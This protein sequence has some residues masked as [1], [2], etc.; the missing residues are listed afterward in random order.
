MDFFGKKLDK[1]EILKHFAKP[2]C[3]VIV[4][5]VTDSTNTRARDML[6]HGA[7]A[8]FLLAAEEQTAGRGRHGNSFFSPDSGLYY[9]LVIKPENYE[10]AVAKTTIAAAVSLQEAILETA[11]IS[12]GIKWVNDLYLNRKKVA[13]ILCEAPRLPSGDPAGI[14]IG[15]GINIAQKEFPEELK[16][17]A[18]SLNRPDLD[19]NILTA[20]LTDRL[21]YWCGCLESPELMKAYKDASV[22]LGKEVS[23]VQNGKTITG[24]A[25]DINTDGNLIV[26]ADRTYVL[27]SGEISLTSW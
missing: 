16:D 10:S 25:E 21:L 17:K 15:I 18:G 2:V 19:R 7:P 6:M 23:F 26:H 14:I 13:G 12:C 8:P 22:L 11:G 24:I 27:N 3:N 9:S 20:V 4:Y 1:S 5:E